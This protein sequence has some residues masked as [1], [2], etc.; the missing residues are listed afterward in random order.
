MKWN[1]K[2]SEFFGWKWF[3][4]FHSLWSLLNQ[5]HWDFIRKRLIILLNE[6]NELVRNTLLPVT[7]ISNSSS[8]TTREENH[9]HL[10]VAIHRDMRF[11]FQRKQS[12]WADDEQTE[13]NA[14]KQFVVPSFKIKSICEEQYLCVPIILL[15][16]SYVIGE[17]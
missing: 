6:H 16:A 10:L 9:L 12:M 13:L 11:T 4:R 15:C 14:S 2:S 17:L 3:H 1:R 7:I 8:A 5:T